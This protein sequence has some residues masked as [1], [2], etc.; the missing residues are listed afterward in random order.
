M[1][2]G[3]GKRPPVAFLASGVPMLRVTCLGLGGQRPLKGVEK[4]VSRGS[5]PPHLH[6]R[7]P[8]LPC[9]EV[10]CVQCSR[11]LGRA[12]GKNAEAAEAR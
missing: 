3:E 7:E 6:S 2:A 1:V 5:P 8:G 9:L 11:R 10:G 4:Q 12:S